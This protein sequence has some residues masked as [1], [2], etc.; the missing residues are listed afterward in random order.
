MKFTRKTEA[1]SLQNG[2]TQQISMWGRAH[3]S[4]QLAG[5]HPFLPAP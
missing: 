4:L 2:T 5:R 1:Q 3:S